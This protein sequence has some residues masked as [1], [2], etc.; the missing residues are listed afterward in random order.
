MAERTLRGARLGGQSFE[1]E[2]GIEFAA[3]QQVGYR[4]PQGHDFEITMSVEADVPANWEC[5]RCGAVGLSTAGI[6]PEEKA[7]KPARTHW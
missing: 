1:D 5:P 7:E 4:C 6:L 2:R 3:R